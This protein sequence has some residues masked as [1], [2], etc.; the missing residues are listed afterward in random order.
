MKTNLR[1]TDPDTAWEFQSWPEFANWPDPSSS[2]VIVPVFG[3][4]SWHNGWPLDAEELIGTRIL[5]A[6]LKSHPSR[7]RLLSLP[8]LRFCLGRKSGSAFN[9]DP[10]T[11]HPA[12]EEIARSIHAA[13]FR[14][15]VFL[16]GSPWNKE[17]LDAAGRD[18]RISLG[19]QPF[20]ITLQG[21]GIDLTT[22]E[23]DLGQS[24]EAILRQ[25]P[26]PSLDPP[27]EHLGRLLA[28]VLGAQ[29]LKNDGTIPTMTWSS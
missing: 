9:V 28:E 13:G 22:E 17:L 23:M 14:K 18:L 5:S 11:A 20:L 26:C 3:F 15:I 7:D 2:V 12:V 25:E 19:V 4:H 24:L 8:P 27:V 21:I 29:P 6:C 16:N 1:L 10:E